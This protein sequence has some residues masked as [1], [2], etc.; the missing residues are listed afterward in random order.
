MGKNLKAH[1]VNKFAASLH[2][3]HG[4]Y[5]VIKDTFLT[6]YWLNSLSCASPPTQTPMDCDLTME[7]T[8]HT[9]VT[10]YLSKRV[11][12]LRN[13]LECNIDVHAKTYLEM[14]TIVLREKMQTQ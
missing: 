7:S 5:Q 3:T 14:M 12:M 10:K 2:E 8:F 9:C 4:K 11:S 6:H 1:L 13:V